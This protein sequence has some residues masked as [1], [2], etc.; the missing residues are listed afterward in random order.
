GLAELATPSRRALRETQAAQ[1]EALKEEKQVK[2]R[3]PITA[4]IV[5]ALV[6]A[7]GS[8][9]IIFG[10]PIWDSLTQKEPPAI[11]DYP[12]PGSGQAAI[13]IAQG[14]P[15][16]VIADKLV[17]A[18]VIA[19]AG[20]FITA[21]TN[22]GDRANSI[23]PGVC[24]G[25]R[26]QMS[27]AG[28][29]EALLRTDACV[30]ITFI[31]PEGKRAEEVYALVGEAIA[32]PQLA[33]DADQAAIDQA[34]AD[35]TALVRQAAADTAAIG[36]PAEANGLVEGWLLPKGYQFDVG[37]TPTEVLS[38]M[39][40]ARVA[41]LEQLG[42]P[43]ER[44]HEVIVLA[45][46]VEKEARLEEDRPKVARVFFN[47]LER[48]M[49]LQSDATVVYGVSRFNSDPNTSDIE[50]DDDNPYNTYYI[51]ALPIGAICNPGAAA[52]EAVLNPTPGA[53]LYFVTVN[54]DTGETEFNETAEGHDRSVAKLRQW[55]RE[56][57]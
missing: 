2:R 48:D 7:V 18:G 5:L 49:K 26:K 8:V 57:G 32:R 53:W 4:V 54:L 40:A 6:V 44:W 3:G 39:V 23:Q 45:S 21:F 55:Q 47:R 31:I 34:V 30:A 19:S 25:L 33:T 43:R 15:G 22:A 27:A 20:P 52:I 13:T 12:G 10:K 41:E 9:G 38:R 1:T 56:H 46:M 17:G 51:A 36:L 42:V 35:Q 24:A 29:L 16:S 50:R 28:A 11:T 14:D 37:A